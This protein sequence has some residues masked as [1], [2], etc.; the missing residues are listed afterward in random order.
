[1][2]SSGTKRSRSDLR[3]H[4]GSYGSMVKIICNMLDYG[5]NSRLQMPVTLNILVGG[6]TN[7]KDK[8]RW[9]RGR[10]ILD[11]CRVMGPSNH[12]QFPLSPVSRLVNP[13]RAG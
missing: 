6:T 12:L 7:I 4:E 3:D 5:M 13:V 11:N 2:T 8:A 10:G 9:M 1:M